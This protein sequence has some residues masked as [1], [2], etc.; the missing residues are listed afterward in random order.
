MQNA[1]EKIATGNTYGQKLIELAEKDSRIVVV[2]A[3]LMRASGSD[4]F[5]EQ[6][7]ERHF[8]VG[9]AEQ[10][11]V[12]VAAGLAAMGKIPFA[13]SFACFAARRACDQAMVSAAYNNL[14]VNIVGSYAGLTTEK[15][16][17]THI[18]IAD[19]AIFRLMPNFTVLVP[20]D[21]AELA[22]AIE[23]A[24]KIDGPVYIRMARGPMPRIFDDD[25]KFSLGQ[26]VTLR[27][28]NE[29]TLITT[30]ITT[31]EGLCACEELAGKGIDVRHLHM[32]SIKPIDK[33]A[34]IE[35]AKATKAIFTVENHSKLGGLGSAVAEIICESCPAPVIRLG[36][37]D[38][39]GETATLEYLMDIHGISAPRIVEA[40]EAYLEKVAT[41]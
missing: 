12:G 13:S 41:V 11:L 38:C 21:C 8:N 35:A 18:S 37:D 32:P 25:C 14:N 26:A 1:I 17:G 9:I 3:D 28:G 23:T 27:A 22:G 24:A 4:A 19:I 16:G 29:I 15:N 39:F 10:N 40:V 5:R 36:M 7:P 2:E 6:F 30:G 34:I 33:E 31:W 20:G